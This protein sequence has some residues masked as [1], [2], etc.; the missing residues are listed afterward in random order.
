MASLFGG[1]EIKSAL[2][3]GQQTLLGSMTSTLNDLWMR[4]ADVYRGQ[5]VA[6]RTGLMNLGL[7]MAAGGNDMQPYINQASQHALSGAEDPAAVMARYQSALGPAQLEFQ[8]AQNEIGNRYGSAYG[9]SGPM[10]EMMGRS[11]AEYGMGLNSLLG[12]LTYNDRNAARDRQAGAIAPAAGA[13]RAGMANIQDIYGMG[14][15][16]RAVTQQGYA[17]DYA[18]WLSGQ[19]YNNP[20][21]GFISPALGTQANVGAQQQGAL[22]PILG[23]AGGLVNM[24]STFGG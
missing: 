10:A 9:T 20:A 5:T 14:E 1:T 15:A 3:P 17:S 22:G 13:Q 23:M 8:R 21:L 7:D 19:W 18:K 12:E 11:A 6:P 2:A 4:P 24:G 16:D